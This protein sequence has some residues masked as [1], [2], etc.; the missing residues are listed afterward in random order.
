MEQ[1]RNRD[2]QN[3]EGLPGFEPTAESGIL[4]RLDSIKIGLS[5]WLQAYKETAPDDMQTHIHLDGSLDNLGIELKYLV[6]DV[7]NSED[8]HLQLDV[9]S[10]PAGL[11]EIRQRGDDRFTL[12]DRLDIAS[13][14]ALPVNYV[15][16]HR[17]VQDMA[18]ALPQPDRYYDTHQF[19]IGDSR[20]G[21]VIPIFPLAEALEEDRAALKV[22]Q[23]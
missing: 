15:D 6:R 20:R 18:I 10:V 17:V 11:R 16:K 1:N 22:V 5:T 8:H 3:Y 19:H 13:L 9:Y 14:P 21:I 4:E 2:F 23:Q 7:K 12:F